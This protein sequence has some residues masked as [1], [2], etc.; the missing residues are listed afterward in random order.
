MAFKVHH[1]RNGFVFDR[2]NDTGGGTR[3]HGGHNVFVGDLVLV[4]QRHAHHA[5]DGVGGESKEP[6]DGLQDHDQ[7]EH[8]ADHA[9]GNLFGAAHGHALRNQVGEHHKEYRHERHGAGERHAGH[10]FGREEKAKERLKKHAENA[11]TDDTAQNGNEVNAHLHDREEVARVFLE[12]KHLSST[13]VAVFGHSRE[14]Y[15]ARAGECNFRHGKVGRGHNKQN[16]ES[17]VGEE[18]HDGPLCVKA[19]KDLFPRRNR[20]FYFKVK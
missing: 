10:E 20:S 2:G 13:A 17:K 9:N 14:A 7:E 3:F 1:V 19:G 16:N 11:F 18:I 6:D 8:E 12:L 5:H 15:L 4:L